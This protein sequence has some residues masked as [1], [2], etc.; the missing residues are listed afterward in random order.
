MSVASEIEAQAATWLVRRD[1]APLSPQ[2]QSAFEAWMYTDPR[3]RATY[4]RLEE[5]W[6]RADRLRW[7]KPFDGAV[8]EDLLGSS[9]FIRFDE[10]PA[11]ASTKQSPG[12][13][14]ADN[15]ANTDNF[16]H[17]SSETPDDPHALRA[18]DAPADRL[19]DSPAAPRRRRMFFYA[20]AVAAVALLALATGLWL[21]FRQPHWQRYVTD[22]GGFER[23]ALSDGSTV[24][25]NTNSVIR[26]LMS[27]DRRQIVLDRGEALF[28]VAH[29]ASR[30]FDVQ[31]GGTTVRAVGTEFS[32]RVLE[33]EESNT[34]QQNV[35]VFVKEGR[36]AI[37]PTA[38]ALEQSKALDVPSVPTL[39]AGES[40]TVSA[41][42]L[43]V[44]KVADTDVSRKLSWVEGRLWFERQRLAD[45]VAEFNRYNRRQMV[46]TDPAIADL[47]I[48]GGFEA[49]DPESFT[50]ALERT[51]PIHVDRSDAAIVR[52]SAR[53]A[54]E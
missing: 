7:L 15:R 50:A 42:R 47:R 30:P 11:R 6:R 26:V 49:T 13:E 2:E 8:D 38:H 41:K 53:E 36:V 24:H 17:R 29:D 25:L 35:E 20:L 45:V 3:H 4:L 16:D 54:E 40:V 51:L 48:G 33:K 14:S 10:R 12:E 27:K 46:I 23:V 19:S 37:D 21:T 9:P 5:A 52:L 22:L 28:K 34:G 44:A 39:L 43:Y 32:V 18:G 31:A 1:A